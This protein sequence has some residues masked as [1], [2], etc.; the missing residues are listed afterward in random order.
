[1]P[2]KRVS[3][4]KEEPRDL[5]GS[6]LFKLGTRLGLALVVVFIFLTLTQCTIER[7][8]APQWDTQLT[9]PV[10]NRTYLMPE[11]IEKINQEGI[12]LDG[13][14]VV[15]SI[16]EDVDTF[17]ISA[18]ELRTDDLAFSVSQPLGNVDLTPPSVDPLAV[19]YLDIAGLSAGVVLPVSFSQ[20]TVLPPL[21][22]YSSISIVNGAAVLSIG[23]NLGLDLDTVILEL[24]DY[25]SGLLIGDTSFAGGLATG[26]SATA[27]FDL[28][29]KTLSN[30]FEVRLFCHTPGGTVLSADNKSLTTDIGFAQPLTVSSAQ[31]SVPTLSRTFSQS[32]DLNESEPVQSAVLADGQLTLN[33]SNNAEFDATVQLTLPDLIYNGQPLVISR[34]VAGSGSIQV[35]VSLAG[36]EL[37]PQDQSIPQQI[38]VEVLAAT[39]G[40][41]GAI[42]AI[43]QS[44][45]F[46][47][48]ADLAGLQFASITGVFNN[49]AASIDPSTQ[50]IDVPEGFDYVELQQAVLALEI[51][52]HFNLAGDISVTVVGNNGKSLSISGVIDAALPGTPVTTLLIDSTVA[53]FLNPLPS[54]IDISGSAT[55]GDGSTVATIND[56]DFVYAQ[57]HVTAPL[58]VI[59]AQDTE[60]EADVESEDIDQE[61]IDV[62][63]DHVTEARFVYTIVNHLPLGVDVSIFL[64]GDSATLLSAP[65]VLIDGLSVGAAPTVAGIVSDTI[66][67]GQ[68]TIILDNADIQVLNNDTLF[69]GQQIILQGTGGQAVRLTGDDYVQVSGYLEVEYRFDGEF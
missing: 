48:T 62:I 60:V 41:G 36:Y 21:D 35:P 39:D 42:V 31:A 38:A 43:D 23:N 55:F 65:Q 61:D 11:L 45:S 67:T 3:R 40:S 14:S 49:T 37:A 7:P 52:N 13:N 19:S 15:F 56:A 27:T 33:I 12:S 47:V 51:E 6:P 20:D 1:M 63:T 58:E 17:A 57:V 59:I 44:D 50:S 26:T 54:Q 9:V 18:E 24:Y 5:F 2:K 25:Q 32:V 64:G 69:I 22:E 28:G 16:S 34:P 4:D 30:E 10:V 66:S 68:Q 29:G 8:K 53:D 46:A